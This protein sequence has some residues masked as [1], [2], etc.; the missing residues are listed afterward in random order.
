MIYAKTP[1]VFPGPGCFDEI[2][3]NY[4]LFSMNIIIPAIALALACWLAFSKKLAKSEKWQATVTPLAS[5]MG[6]GFLISAP[7][8]GGL[9]GK[10][11]VL[12][13]A[14]LLVLAF[15]V[16]SALRYNIRHFEPI[17]EEKGKIQWLA[18]V[19]RFV[20][21]GAYFITVV[22]YL[23]LLAAFALKQMGISSP[24]AADFITTGILL[25]IGLIGIWKGLA[26]LEKIEEYAIALNL[27]MIGA[28]L[29]G[30]VIFNSKLL[31]TGE[32]S[33]PDVDSSISRHDLRV[34]LGL[35]IVVQ[36]FETSRYLGM[37]HSAD[38]RIKTMRNAQ[39][40]SGVIYLVFVGLATVLF[41]NKMGAEVT[42]ILNLSAEVA[43]VL[44][45][46]LTIAAVGS[47]FSAAVADSAGAGGLIEDLTKQRLPEKYAYIIILVVT[48]ILAWLVDVNEVI[49]L[50][51]RAFALFYAL[52][53]L[54]AARL[55]FSSDS[56][57]I[58]RFVFFAVLA[59]ICFSVFLF[60]IPAEG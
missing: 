17:E 40:L 37:E 6:S 56:K 5:I 16:G 2:T 21:T 1:L 52:Q 50:A 18:L 25:F 36:G 19:S 27:G 45:F 33:L 39:L 7:L 59:M 23:E 35:L 34:L 10:W 24:L 22:Y 31:L 46:L 14:A 54:I 60:G 42:T 12:F 29:A 41:H 47:Q 51:S 11:A 15:C 4:P 26:S 9:V 20:L 13:M 38:L 48:I 55:A 58:P 8:L 32:W 28:L 3:G 53:C 44:P 43:M 49:A 30:L 57:S